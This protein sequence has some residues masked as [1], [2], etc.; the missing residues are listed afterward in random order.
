MCQTRSLYKRCCCTCENRWTL[1]ET[2][3]NA[4]WER[5]LLPS[6]GRGVKNREK[7]IEEVENNLC[8]ALH[9]ARK[10]VPYGLLWY[11]NISSVSPSNKYIQLFV[12]SEI[13]LNN[14]SSFFLFWYNA[15]YSL[16][17]SHLLLSLTFAQTSRVHRLFL[18]HC[19]YVLQL[20]SLLHH[21]P[22]NSRRQITIWLRLCRCRCVHYNY[23]HHHYH[24]NNNNQWHDT[25]PRTNHYQDSF[26][27]LIHRPQMLLFGMFVRF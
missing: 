5:W 15:I 23:N 21:T 18:S 16:S 13:Q 6:L 26:S 20:V 7:N 24:G 10:L 8:S 3:L 9:L 27:K 17:H 11:I 22:S 2:R 4:Q 14:T 12:P 1:R 19:V 25:A